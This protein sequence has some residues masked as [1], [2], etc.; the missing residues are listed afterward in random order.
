MNLFSMF[1]VLL[2]VTQT[3]VQIPRQTPD[4]PAYSRGQANGQSEGHDAPAA[5][6]MAV[7]QPVT[8]P[9]GQDADG[10]H[11]KDNAPHSVIVSELPTVS[12]AKD[13]ADRGVWW[14]TLCLVVVGAAQAVYVAKTLGAISRQATLMEAQ[15]KITKDKERARITILFPPPDAP[16]KNPFAVDYIGTEDKVIPQV[17]VTQE[18]CVINDGPTWAFDV[19]AIGELTVEQ[20]S[21]PASVQI[22]GENL[23]ILRIIRNP[24]LESPV[25]L[26]LS[27]F[28]D[29]GNFDKVAVGKAF[30]FLTGSVTYW[31]VF[32]TRHETPFRYLWTLPTSNWEDDQPRWIDHSPTS[33]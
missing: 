25:E 26:K 19:T 5:P 18:F 2:I 23:E 21:N 4:G 11:T 6:Y 31:D 29:K 7:V 33:T 16:L 32:G 15:N 27:A 10:E 28:L 3:P 12:I 17:F 20:S 30:L 14:F 8:A 1:A 22:T 24:T 13:W 9:K